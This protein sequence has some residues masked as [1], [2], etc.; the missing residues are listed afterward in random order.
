[1]WKYNQLLYVKQSMVAIEEIHRNDAVRGKDNDLI[2]IYPIASCERM[3]FFPVVLEALLPLDLNGTVFL[4]RKS[5]YIT[6][7]YHCNR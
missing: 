3:C 7:Y 6:L 1:M 5:T 2:V 4:N